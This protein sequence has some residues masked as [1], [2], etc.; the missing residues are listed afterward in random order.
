[1]CEKIPPAFIVKFGPFIKR[2]RCIVFGEDRGIYHYKAVW[3]RE[4]D[5]R[6]LYRPLIATL[7]S[8]ACASHLYRAAG[9]PKFKYSYYASFDIHIIILSTQFYIQHAIFT[10]LNSDYQG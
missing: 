10:I 2:Q 7:Q 1:M 5:I 8:V 6:S 9:V 3:P 4:G